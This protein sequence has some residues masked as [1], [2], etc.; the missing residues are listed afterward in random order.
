[1]IGKAKV[2]DLR[3]KGEFFTLKNQLPHTSQDCLGPLKEPSTIRMQTFWNSSK[4]K[5]FHT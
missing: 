4:E 1:M 5:S 3:K 2:L